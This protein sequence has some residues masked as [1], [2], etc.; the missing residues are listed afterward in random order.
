MRTAPIFLL[1]CSLAALRGAAQC[2]IPKNTYD[3]V[4]PVT[5]NI[6]YDSTYAWGSNNITGAWNVVRTGNNVF[7]SGN[8]TDIGPNQGAG[9]V[10]DS[11]SKTLISKMAWRI[12]GPVRA[13]VPDGSGG[14]YIGGDFTRIG[15]SLRN[16]IARIDAMGRPAPW[17]PGIDQSVDA[18]YITNDSL[19]LGGSFTSI[20][21]KTRH[22]FAAWSLSG[23]SVLPCQL[24][25]DASLAIG[26]ITT[27]KPHGAGKLF[28]GGGNL[29]ANDGSF[30]SIVDYDLNQ[31]VIT[32]WKPQ[33]I[34]YGPVTSIDLS[35]NGKIVAYADQYTQTVS[36]CD[37]TTGNQLYR[38]SYSYANAG[39]NSGL[40]Y[41]L[42]TVG[43]LLYI[44]GAFTSVTDAA[45]SR[46]QRNGLCAVDF[47][48]GVLQN[49]NLN[50]NASYVPYVDVCNG[51]LVV[52]GPFTQVGDSAR[53]HFAMLDTVTLALKSWNPSPSDEVNTVCASGS[54][55]FLGGLFNGIQFV[56]RNGLAGFDINTGTVQPFNPPYNTAVPPI[57][58]TKKMLIRGDSL[59]VL[60]HTDRLNASATE[61]TTFTL[62][63]LSTGEI[64]ASPLNALPSLHDILFD[65]PY[66]YATDDFIIERY[67]LPGLGLDGGWQVNCN[68]DSTPHIPYSLCADAN[69][70]YS[71]GDDRIEP[72]ANLRSPRNYAFLCKINKT[73]SSLQSRYEYLDT[74]NQSPSAP[75][76]DLATVTDSLIFVKGEFNSL[77]GTKTHSLALI[78]VNNGHPLN[79][80]SP[81][82]SSGGSTYSPLLNYIDKLYLRQGVL[83]FGLNYGQYPFSGDENISNPLVFSAVDSA[84][85]RVLPSPVQLSGTFPLSVSDFS[86]DPDYCMIVGSFATGNGQP[87]RHIAR[88]SY[89]AWSPPTGAL[90][91]AGPDTIRVS[92]SSDTVGYALP[93]SLA[94]TWTYSGTAT[95][96]LNNAGNPAMLS[97]APNAT[98]GMLSATG[99]GY[100]GT[101]NS[102][103]QKTIVVVRVYP[104]PTANAC[105]MQ[106]S[107]LQP[108]QL[109]LSFSA[110]NGSGRIVVASTSPTAAAPVNTTAYSASSQFGAGAALGGGSP[111]TGGAGF[112]V[113]AGPANSVTVTGLAPSTRYYFTIYEYNGSGDS[114]AYLTAGAYTGNASTLATAPQIPASRLRFSNI[115]TNSVTLS[116]T[117]GSGT[118]RL[119]LFKTNDSIISV[120]A[121]GSSY[122]S[123]PRYQ[124]GYQFPDNSFVVAN[125]GDSVAISNLA[126][127]TLYYARIV[128]FAG[129]GD[130]INYDLDFPPGDTVRTLPLSTAGDSTAATSPTVPASGLQ[131]MNITPN[132]AQ[133]SCTPGNGR[134]RLF[135][136]H[137]LVPITNY[138]VDGVSY[139]ADTTFGKGGD[140]GSGTWVLADTGTTLTAAGLT[141]NT[142]YYVAVF[143]Y[144]NNPVSSAAYLLGSFPM[145]FFTTTTTAVGINWQD[146]S[147]LVTAYPN[148]AQQSAF[149]RVQANVMATLTV[150][151]METS[152]MVLGTYSFAASLGPN[153]F[154]LKN[155]ASLPRGIYLVSWISAGHKGTLTLYKD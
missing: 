107:N 137:S 33:N 134:N 34:A 139:A 65:G 16:H 105:C 133:I 58:S 140:L 98:G 74:L 128:E 82:I 12:N 8:F 23:D 95:T 146:S 77:N 111:G 37:V 25:P 3:T 66:M 62:Y 99:K 21:G 76:F 80:T 151:V 50:L 14:F 124:Y 71:V 26:S 31:A 106:F 55:L 67:A 64:M 60:G 9:V 17:N 41:K 53:E 103:A 129:S 45:G 63:R 97:F 86:F 104:N 44:A 46:M 32:G 68:N 132:S 11:G 57:S 125:T 101:S 113:Y 40:V 150:N 144:N 69:N 89:G 145:A 152:G 47:S 117:P 73:I 2:V 54:R 36:A 119:Y 127:A 29:Y 35:P 78:D 70:I 148:P 153:T 79:W 93:D 75:F 38:I 142:A 154:E 87:Q 84:S 121:A 94:Y 123:D 149:I 10:I 27:L 110:G 1:I 120:P 43:N 5:N 136:I 20:G 18:L 126:P 7:L 51:N 83:W 112:V 138:P 4:T 102:T 130:A 131:F 155:F 61:E 22:S 91:I 96:I 49:I 6:L 135:V 115:G 141:P 59:F 85:G 13:A 92:T 90:T 39:V 108:T 72:L 28:I 42:K 48:T 19:F 24:Y 30:A 52:S 81:L 109:S 88:L 122:Y 143:E 100:C 15:D 147:F 118:G 56:H 114:I 116:C